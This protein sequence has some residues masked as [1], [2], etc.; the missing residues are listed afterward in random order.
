LERGRRLGDRPFAASTAGNTF[1]SNSVIERQ[2]QPLELP[3]V[4]FGPRDSEVFMRAT[5]M[6]TATFVVAMLGW[7]TT[8]R[9]QGQAATWLD[10]PRPASHAPTDPL[11]CSSKT[12]DVVFEVTGERPV[13][14]P[15]SAS[16]AQSASSSSAVQP[17]EGPYWKAIELAGKPTPAQDPQ[18]EAHL[19]FQAG[20]RVSGSDG[21]NRLTGTYQRSG[22]RVTFGQMAGTQMAC[23]NATGTEEAFRDAL[24]NVARFTINGDRLEFFDASGTRLAVFSATTRPSSRPSPIERLRARFEDR[25][26]RQALFNGMTYFDD[27]RVTAVNEAAEMT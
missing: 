1:A 8:G 11:C 7:P 16:T 24:K 27:T 2:W 9:S 21:C 4:A 15:V 18:R 19:Q 14:T 20:G 22:D 25:N 23:L 12:R 17:L 3:A 6:W 5:C 13:V 10:E 26:P